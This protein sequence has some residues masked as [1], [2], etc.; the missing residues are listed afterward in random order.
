MCSAMHTKC[1]EEPRV[2]SMSPSPSSTRCCPLTGLEGGGAMEDEEEME[3]M[4][5]VVEEGEMEEEEEE[6]EQ[7]PSLPRPL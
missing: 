3:V 1:C 2:S 7:G 6:E 5:M 4:V